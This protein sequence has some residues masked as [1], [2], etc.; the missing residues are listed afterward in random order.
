MSTDVMDLYGKIKLDTSDYK[1]ALSDCSSGMSAFK[2]KMKAGFDVVAKAGAAAVS[3]AAA[4]TTKIVSDSV[5]AYG[6][7]EQLVGGIETLFGDSA[8]TVLENSEMAFKTAGMSMNEYMETSIQSAA[9]M[10]SSLGGDQAKAAEY[11]N[12]SIIDMSDNVNKMG[13]TMEAVQNAYRGFSKQNFT[14]LDNLALGY[15]GTKEEMKRL[16]ADATAISGIEFDVSSYSDIVQAIHIIQQEMGITGTT[17]AEAADTSQGS[18]GSMAAAWENLKIELVK[19]DGDI[20]K[21]IDIMVNSALT[22]FDNIE[23]KIERAMNGMSQFMEKAAPVIAEKLPPI[24]EKVVPPLLESSA[25]LVYSVGK[26]I[27]K[28]VP[29]LL[30]SVGG[31][32]T[33]LYDKFTSTNLGAFDWLRQD[34]VSVVNTVKSTIGNIDFETIIEKFSGFGSVV[35]DALEKIGGGVAWVTENIISP[36]VEWASNDIL[37]VVI[38]GI[39]SSFSLL[40][41]ALNFLETPAKAVWEEFLQPLGSIAGDVIYGSFDLIAKGLGA[42]HEAVDGVDWEGWWID[43]FSGNF[44]EDWQAGWDD[45]KMNIEDCG[46]AID[47][48]FDVSEFGRTWNELWQGV[49]AAVYDFQHNQWAEFKS[50]WAFGCSELASDW[51]DFIE[52]WKLGAD[53]LVDAGKKVLEILGRIKETLTRDEEEPEV[54]DYWGDASSEFGRMGIGHFA[55]GTVV[56]RPTRALIGEAGAEAVIPLENNTG[57]IDEL[58]SRLNASG[59]SNNTPIVAN[60]Y[61]DGAY[62]GSKEMA[63]ELAQPMSEELQR[64]YNRNNRGIS[65]QYVS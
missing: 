4:A 48:F 52:Q 36:V 20:G 45:L 53:V 43:V 61:F 50:D 34:I 37:P 26:S 28:A 3:A 54:P 18:A 39:T 29:S 19:E 1:A 33:G 31:L 47:E 10:I 46:G 21:S 5:Q 65:C 7:Y 12:M 24:I 58:A 16:L 30:S 2:E 35:G 60:F 40:T 64:L 42:V 41:D 44:S 57:F 59:A 38:D 13:T 56:T 49:G 63:K 17:A 6:S 14:M 27:A 62:I 23:P 22:A 15:G 8:Q 55:R 11:M 25:T 32:A 51:D 9:S